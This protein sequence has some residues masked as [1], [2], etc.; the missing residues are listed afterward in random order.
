MIT[1]DLVLVGGGHSHALVLKRWG[2]KPLP[3]V[4]LTLISDRS[5]AP[6]SGMLPGYVAGFYGFEECHIDLRHLAEFAGAQFYL[7]RAVGL[8]LVQ[9]RVHCDRHPPV[10]YDWVSIDIGSVPDCQSIPG[11]LGGSL[12][13]IPVKPVHQFLPAWEQLLEEM[14]ARPDYPWQLAIVGGGA[15][16]V[17]LALALQARIQR[18]SQPLQRDLTVQFHLIHRDTHLM[19]GHA[20]VVQH[21]FER[22]LQQRKIVVHLQEQVVAIDSGKPCSILRTAAGLTLSCD[23]IFWTTQATPAPWIATS[24]LA[25]DDRGF[26]LVTETLQ[27]CSHPQVFAAGDIATLERH[28]RPKAGVFAVRQG[29]PLYE[30]LTRVLQGKAPRP[31][32]PQKALLALI[33]DGQGQAAASRGNW[34]LPLSPL[35]WH[36]KDHIDRR[37]MAKFQNLPPRMKMG[38]KMGAMQPS[39]RPEPMYCAGCGSK[40]GRGVLDTTLQRLRQ[41]GRLQSQPDIVVGLEGSDDAA[42]LQSQPDRLLVQSVDFFPSPFADPFLTGQVVTE[43]CLNDLYALGAD[44]H[45]ALAIVTLPHGKPRIQEETLYQLLTGIGER[46]QQVGAVL[47][48]GH[49]TE[50]E[51]LA[52]G[53][54]CNGWV[55]PADLWDKQQVPLD[56]IPQAQAPLDQVPQ[57][58]A[59]ILTKALGTGTLFVAQNQGQAKA[60]WLDAAIDSMTLSHAAAVKILRHH[61][62]T[63]CTDVT[64]FG[65]WGHALDLVRWTTG[66]IHLDLE[67]LPLLPGV[68]DSLENGHFS[69]LYPQNLR[70]RQRGND[71]FTFSSTNPEHHPEHHPHWPVLFDPQ[72]AGGLLAAVPQAQAQACLEALRGAGYRQSAIV[73]W[74]G[75]RG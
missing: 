64:G 12:G 65:L 57:A 67:A 18:L 35:L 31:F 20:P 23:R 54:A 19:T 3:G 13:G 53:L 14:Q 41:E 40:V 22:C 8:N 10:A 73:G 27:S 50:G 63:A 71:R 2:M 49:T 38:A 1:T 7:D 39:A 66:Q 15:G 61:G 45:S 6:Y 75:S 68:L 28:P 43:H 17:E 16:G 9:H 59:L 25:T 58:Q 32:V 24:G 33:G 51:A 52:L 74:I 69:S 11:S 37:F 44:P 34:G 48:G 29:K 47:L 55:S 30:N 62:T 56:Q 46:L 4:R 36:W 26:I 5:V 72:T 42:V 60:A 70:D 21:T